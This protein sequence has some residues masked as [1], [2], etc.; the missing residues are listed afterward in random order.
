MGNLKNDRQKMFSPFEPRTENEGGFMREDD[1]HDP[2]P[3]SAA[4]LTRRRVLFAGGT[5]FI[6]IFAQSCASRVTPIPRYVS[7]AAH[8]I[9]GGDKPTYV[10]QP[11]DKNPVSHSLGDNL[12]WNDILME[13]AKFFTMLMPG[14][15]LAEPRRQ[16]EMF[17][18]SFAK[19][20][21]AVQRTELDRGNFASFNRSTIELVKPFIEYKRRMQSEQSRGRMHSLVWPTFFDHTAHEAERFT[22]RL[23]N[24]SRG[25][26]ELDRNEVVDF[27]TQIMAEHADFIA[28]LLD[29]KD[30]YVETAFKTSQTFRALRSKR[31][32]PKTSGQDPVL[33]AGEEFHDFKTIAV[34]GIK[35][36]LIKSIIDPALA[37]HVRREAL[38]FIDELKRA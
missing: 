16:A 11:G 31:A 4:D 1:S 15:E 5:A 7:A 8:I 38:K 33:K 32:E 19:Q 2:L 34:K 9:N 3:F 24:L 26:S 22:R 37:D 10:P 35:T 36:G 14:P 29:P 23:E 30:K 12:F 20:F 28:H 25:N 21:A 6:G 17:Q 18:A 27:W 13:H